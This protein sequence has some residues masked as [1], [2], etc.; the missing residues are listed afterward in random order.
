MSC[1]F[2]KLVNG[3]WMIDQ[4][5]KMSLKGD[6][7]PGIQAYIYGKELNI[8]ADTYEPNFMEA[9]IEIR[10]CPMCGQKLSDRKI[11]DCYEKLDC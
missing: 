4:R 10:F 5:N 9:N 7:Y 3:E 11:D 8:V 1:D 2:C 6:F